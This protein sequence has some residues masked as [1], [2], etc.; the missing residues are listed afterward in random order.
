MRHRHSR[1]QSGAIAEV[2]MTP[3][4]D[5]VF[6]LLIFFIVTT[7]FVK[8]TG[9]DISRPSAKT[10]VQKELAN[11]LI[12]IKPNGEVWMDG[13]QIEQ[14]A[15]RAN[16]ERMHAENPEGSVIILADKE[17]KTGLLIEVM[18]Q[19]RLAGVA[20]VSIAAERD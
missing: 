19:A 15:V 3:L 2:N 7:S 13:R 10:A 16:V 9:V 18:D 14:R 17:A 1:R 12:A 8:E 4:I 20:N 6:I 5:M 11:I